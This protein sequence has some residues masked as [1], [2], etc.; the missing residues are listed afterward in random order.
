MGTGFTG[1]DRAHSIP[2]IRTGIPR[3]YKE[4]NRRAAALLAGGCMSDSRPYRLSPPSA[5]TKWR[6]RRVGW[7]AAAK[8]AAGMGRLD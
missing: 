1:S 2:S 6:A 4:P 8:A 7:S 3:A 5:T